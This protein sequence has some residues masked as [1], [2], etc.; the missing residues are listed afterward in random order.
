M[1]YAYR[2]QRPCFVL[3]PLMSSS[4]SL[5]T[6]P[7]LLFH[8]SFLFGFCSAYDNTGRFFLVFFLFPL[9]FPLASPTPLSHHQNGFSEQ[10]ARSNNVGPGGAM[11]TARGGGHISPILYF[12]FFFQLYT[13]CIFFCNFNKCLV[14]FFCFKFT[15]STF[16]HFPLL[17]S[18]QGMG[19][20]AYVTVS[21]MLGQLT[22]KPET[23][24]GYIITSGWL[25]SCFILAASFTAELA[26]F[27]TVER[28]AAVVSVHIRT[29][30]IVLTYFSKLV[31]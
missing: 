24:E 8:S 2:R 14:V 10:S 3:F 12:F 9:L 26:S 23:L 15:S 13:F 21:L 25:F 6:L 29:R 11:L 30:F 31:F 7:F 17:S 18:P 16:L 19:Q 28:E 1:S 5:S 27:L 20:S 4:R 22:H